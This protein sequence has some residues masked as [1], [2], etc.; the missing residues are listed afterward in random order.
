[1]G[2]SGRTRSFFRRRRGVDRHQSFDE[3]GVH[4]GQQSHATE[5]FRHDLQGQPATK[6]H[7]H[8]LENLILDGAV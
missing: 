2:A 5:E 1:M 8:R 6:S 4:I 7:A 3:L